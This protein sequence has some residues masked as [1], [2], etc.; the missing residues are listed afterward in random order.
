MEKKNKKNFSIKISLSKTIQNRTQ[1]LEY[2]FVS[3]YI[4]I[5]QAIKQEEEDNDN[6]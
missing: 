3:N 2:I 1:N 6:H 4:T 5:K